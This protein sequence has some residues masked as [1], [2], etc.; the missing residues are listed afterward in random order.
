MSDNRSLDELRTFL[1][2]SKGVDSQQ[3]V[4]FYNTWAETY[5]QDH[6]FMKYTAPNQAVNFLFENFSGRPEEVQVLD[7]ACGSGWVAK[8][9]FELGFKHFVGVDGSQGMLDEAAKTGHYE[10]LKLAL[11][12][13][14][15][16]PTQPGVFDVV[17]IVGAL[18]DG[19]VPVSVTR[20][21]CLAAKA[22]G[23]VC[24]SRNGLKTE[25][26]NKY[27]ESLESELQLMQDEGLW[28]HVATKQIDKYMLDVSID[29]Q[30]VQLER[31]VPGTL[32][33]YRKSLL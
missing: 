1:K 29:N 10:D 23:Y 22:G 4:K 2:P 24:M 7:V 19:F 20:E 21:L 14:E 11:L 33:L 31:Y 17:I 18:R 15:P 28:S 9:M 3:M 25:S 32:Y 27:K 30:D 12:G 16:L 8:L 26:G 6:N 5:E 13:T